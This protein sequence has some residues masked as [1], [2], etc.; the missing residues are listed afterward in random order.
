MKQ[1]LF[2]FSAIF[3]LMIAIVGLNAVSYKQKDQLPDTEGFPNR[4]TFNTGSTGTRAFYELLEE[5]GRK[6]T[7]RRKSFVSLSEGKDSPKTLVITGDL[8]SEIE[9]K[10]FEYL[11]AWISKGGCLV[12]I[13]RKPPEELLKTS[14]N[15]KIYAIESSTAAKA[16]GTDPADIKAMT[17]R[18]AAAKPVQPT[19]LTRGVN[20][21]QPSHFASS[22][23]F[24]F[25]G[26]EDTKPK[27]NPPLVKPQ[28]R[29]F[30]LQSNPPLPPVATPFPTAEPAIEKPDNVETAALNAP[31][32]HLSNGEKNILIDFPF[33]EGKIVWLTD[34]YIV[35]NAGIGIVDNLQ[36]AINIAAD[37][38]GLI[39]FDEYHQGY[40][41]G[42]TRLLQYFAETPV[43]PIFLQIGLIIFLIL[44]SQSRRFARAL[45]EN[46]PD[47]L[48]K[49]E[50]VSAFAELQR[51]TKAYD[52]A[53][54]NIYSEF[55]RK[56]ARLTGSD[57]FTVSLKELAA[58]I[59]ERGKL[60]E[61][62]IYNLMKRCE[63]IIQGGDTNKNEILRL[64]AHIR[65]IENKLNLKRSRTSARN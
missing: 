42:E 32:V 54:E 19:I 31:F 61:I 9:E 28:S 15:Y 20:A 25:Y 14:S 64:T 52:L 24:D 59:A 21:V 60:N 62:E 26:Y 36:A 40:G 11:Y 63:E 46:E 2:V 55:K 44:L 39:A 47:R 50:Y 23:A 22:A 29:S 4:S 58:L 17:N 16:F 65:E 53:I 33:G 48:S 45:P 3:L 38:D 57:G 49:L 5:T 37:N 7:R 8:K 35:S 10:E 18:T 12:I 1:R 51:R 13:D 27:T 41:E 34:P 6:V 56:A 30:N 43:I